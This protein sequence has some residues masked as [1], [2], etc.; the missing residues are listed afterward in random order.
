MTVTSK[1]MHSKLGT[2]ISNLDAEVLKL[3]MS[4]EE[5]R[6]NVTKY[7]IVGDN[8]DKKILPSYR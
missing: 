7:Q 5:S 4:W 6:E 3:K 2:W 8:W 1:S